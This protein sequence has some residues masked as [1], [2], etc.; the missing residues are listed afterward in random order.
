M[1]ESIVS[2]HQFHHRVVNFSIKNFLTILHA[3]FSY[4]LMSDTRGWKKMIVL[5]E[6]REIAGND[7]QQF[8][9]ICNCMRKE[10]IEKIA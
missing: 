8:M 9:C 10:N 3:Y 6:T 2:L 5:S 1:N 4:D 7:T